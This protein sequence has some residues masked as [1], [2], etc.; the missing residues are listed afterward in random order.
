MAKSNTV[1]IRKNDPG[2]QPPVGAASAASVEISA[3]RNPRA[4]KFN[5]SQR[6]NLNFFGF[7]TPWLLGFIFLTVIPLVICLV[8]SFTNYD[9]L[10]WDSLKFIK[11]NNYARAFI[12]PDARQSLRQTLIWLG[13]YLPLWMVI[14]FGL[15]LL[16]NGVRKAKGFLRTLY[17]L[18]SV[19]PATAVVI[20]WISILDKNSGLL[21]GLISLVRPGTAIGWVSDYSL[22]V[23]TIMILWTTLGTGVI[24]FLAGLQNISD[25]LLEAAKMDGAN[26]WQVLIKIILPLMTPMIFF[27]LIIGLISVF[28]QMTYPLLLSSSRFMGVTPREIYLYMY[29]AYS[30]IMIRQRYGYGSALL[31]L[32]FLG[33]VIFSLILF[34]SQKFW[35]YTD[36][37][38]A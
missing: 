26:G 37:T 5:R 2:M 9:G 34:W 28:Q 16:L 8:I 14:T 7:I 17:Y 6:A 31:W 4:S 1:T 27:Q 38:A 32:L 11:F 36:E 24:I 35:V 19:M 33:I 20:I 18:P 10:N 12:S 13:L 30:E 25:E 15:A 29:N 23:L 22:Q 3:S 21:N